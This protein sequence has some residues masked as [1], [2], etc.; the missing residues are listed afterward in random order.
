MPIARHNITPLYEQIADQLRQEIG[1]GRFEPSGLLPS[2]AEL[3]KRFDVSRV[4]VRLAVGALAERGLVERRR[5]K[6]TFVK[7]KR[8]Q[9]GLNSLRG[10]HDSLVMQGLATDMRLLTVAKRPLPKPLRARMRTRGLRGLYLRRLHSI[11][12]TPVALASTYL[13]PKSINLTRAQLGERSSYAVIERLLGWRIERA[14]LSIRLEQAS[15]AAAGWLDMKAGEGVMILERTSFTSGDR[16][17]E[18]TRFEI[19]PERFEFVLE[20]GGEFPRLPSVKAD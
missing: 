3:T 16:A 12:G 6:G 15:E 14:R 2:E 11:D 1:R 20:S 5:G 7:G 18:H 17:C 9:H 13:P 8:L 4:T 10:F 19:R